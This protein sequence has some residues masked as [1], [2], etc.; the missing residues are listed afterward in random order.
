MARLSVRSAVFLG[1][2]FVLELVA[3]WFTSTAYAQEA[4]DHGSNPAQ[5]L[6]SSQE[7]LV[8]IAHGLT[9]G[10]SV[11]LAGLVAFATLVWIPANRTADPDQDK[12]L[13]LFCGW[14]WA[15]AGLLVVAGL[16]ELPL[17]AVRASGQSLSLGLLEEALFDTR[18][19][20]LWMERIVLGLL[21]AAAATSASR[22]RRPAYWWIAALGISAL[23]LM[24]LTR[25]SHAAA[26]E[27]F[28]P[29]A[30][31]WLH[32]MAASLWMGGLLGFPVLLIGPLRTMPAGTRT[33]LLGRSV[34][35][36]SKVATIAV[37]ALIST[38]LY[39]ALLH[40]PSLSA[41][42]DTPYG[43]ALA[44]KLGFSVFLFAA[45]GLNLMLQGREPFGHLVS[46][47]L[48][49]AIGVFVATGFL[50]SL[51]PANAI[52]PSTGTKAPQFDEGLR[53]P[54]MPLPSLPDDW[55]PP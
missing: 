42:A 22:S 50:T 13:K 21:V 51:P 18:V 33:K 2:I 4:H 1:L 29:F 49:L 55:T 6:L 35:R 5:G 41:L 3:A 44:M 19:G 45:G 36:F 39:A 28:L 43:R 25:Q 30:A 54:P 23:L 47:E 46:A 16:A 31:D 53:Q 34:R 20:Q 14:M 52:Q 48:L 9:L 15:L 40:M 8:S 24:T 37:M 12:T 11:F 32:V 10:A 26:E 27:G 17:Y 38:G 7:P